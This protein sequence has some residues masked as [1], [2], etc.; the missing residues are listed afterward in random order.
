MCAID[1]VS[2]A[3]PLV[4]V[5]LLLANLLFLFLCATTGLPRARVDKGLPQ[6]I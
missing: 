1:Q 6:S 5:L 4:E 3:V 2:P